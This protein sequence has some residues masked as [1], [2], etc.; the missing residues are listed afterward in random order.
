MI[1]AYLFAATVFLVIYLGVYRPLFPFRDPGK[2]G[3][4]IA[5]VQTVRLQELER[6]LSDEMST[7]MSRDLTPSEQ[8]RAQRERRRAISARLEPLTTNVRLCLAFTRKKAMEIR[9]TDPE[10]FTERE[11]LLQHAFQKAQ[12]CSLLLA[13]AKAT[14]LLMPWD[15]QRFLKFHRETVIHEIREVMVLFVKLS[16]TYGE[17]HRENLLAAMDAWELIDESI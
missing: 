16:E 15:V 4:V 6:L 7:L 2:I 8:R 3:D 9:G 10:A 11:W 5:A 1:V 14:R 13:F 17:H 12:S